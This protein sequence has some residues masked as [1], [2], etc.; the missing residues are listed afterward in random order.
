MSRTRPGTAVRVAFAALTALV[1]LVALAGCGDTS[2]EAAG[3]AATSE[4]AS[5]V[6]QGDG[7][8]LTVPAGWEDL[9]DRADEVPQLALA[10]LAYGDT[11]E[12]PFA[13]N[14]NTIV[15]PARGET[16]DDPAVRDEL[17]AQ[18]QDAVG[19]TPRP[20]D[21]VEIDGEQAI[22]QTA[23]FPDSGATL[24]QYLT[25]HDSKTYTLTVTLSQ[26]RAA[27]SESLVGGIVDS[28]TWTG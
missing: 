13:S 16:V 22:G 4:P 24:V 19:V 20:L 1:A 18:V 5:H 26:D 23:T 28:W 17:A 10:D 27:D 15:A 3:S 2:G 21:D 12:A 11:G 25:V 14:L 6:V 8:S 7:Y 9:S